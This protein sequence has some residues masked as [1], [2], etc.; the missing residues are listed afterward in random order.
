MRPGAHH[1]RKALTPLLAALSLALNALLLGF[2]APTPVDASPL[3][4]ADCHKSDGVSEPADHRREQ[5]GRR[6]CCTLCGDLGYAPGAVWTVV[7]APVPHLALRTGIFGES[8]TGSA[9]AVSVLPLGARAPPFL[10]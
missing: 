7:S 2:I 9:T 6:L 3:A 10:S 1:T 5:H 8:H 4:Y